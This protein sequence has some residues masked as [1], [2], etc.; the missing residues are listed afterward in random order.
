M[1]SIAKDN[2]ESENRN[3]TNSANVN[4]NLIDESSES[5]M[6]NSRRSSNLSKFSLQIFDDQKTQDRLKDA[7]EQIITSIGGFGKWQ[8]IKCLYIMGFI[9]MPASFH[10]LQ[11]V[12]YRYELS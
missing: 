8:M 12:F 6:S 11:M 3:G 1:T 9:W 4:T 7:G 5:K 2:H 10:L